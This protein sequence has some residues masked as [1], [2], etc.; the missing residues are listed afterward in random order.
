MERLSTP[1]IPTEAAAP[2]QPPPT[3]PS[4]WRSIVAST[5]EKRRQSPAK[6]RATVQRLLA[7]TEATHP[8]RLPRL[9]QSALRQR[10]AAHSEE[11]R[12]GASTPVSLR[13]VLRNDFAESK[14]QMGA[15]QLNAT[16]LF[17]GA[18]AR[19][20]RGDPGTDSEHALAVRRALRKQQRRLSPERTSEEAKEQSEFPLQAGAPAS[21][22]H[23]P[24]SSSLLLAP[25]R[26]ASPSSSSSSS[27]SSYHIAPP[28]PSELYKPVISK[29]EQLPLELFDNTEGDLTPAQWLTL[30]HSK[31]PGVG[32]PAKALFYDRGEWAW[33]PCRVTGWEEERQVWLI[34]F[35]VGDG[36]VL[37]KEVK[38]LSLLFDDEDADRFARRLDACREL[39]EECLSVRRYT[40]F[41]NA[42]S[43]ALFSPIQPATLHGI[44]GKLM[45]TSEQL[46]VRRQQT[47][48]RLLAEVKDEYN[49]AMKAAIIDY[50]RRDP[51]QEATMAALRLPPQTL[52]PPPPYLAVVPTGPH[53]LPFDALSASLATAHYTRHT[54]AGQVVLALYRAWS[55]LSGSIFF[56]L[57]FTPRDVPHAS[58]PV[59]PLTIS[60]FLIFQQQAFLSLRERCQNEWRALL[61]NLIRDNL[62]SVYKLFVNERDEYDRSELRRFL[63]VTGYMLRDQLTALVEN[64]VSQWGERMQQYQAAVEEA[65]AKEARGEDV[66]KGFLDAPT[67][68]RPPLS[69]SVAPPLF[70]FRLSFE[71]AASAIVF[72]PPLPALQSSL[73]ALLALPGKLTSL[74]HIDSD[75]V[76]L[77][78]LPDRSL[79]SDQLPSLTALIADTSALTASIITASLIQPQALAALYLPYTALLASSATLASQ[80][81]SPPHTLEETR[82]EVL[83][84]R[85][86]AQTV[87]ALSPNLVAFPLLVC[88]VVGLK[89]EL[90]GR[91]EEVVRGL[92]EGLEADVREDCASMGRSFAEMKARLEVVCTD[93]YQMSELQRFVHVCETDSVQAMGATSR[94]PRPSSR[95]CWAS[96]TPSPPRTTSACCRCRAS[97]CSWLRCSPACAPTSP[98]TA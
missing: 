60:D 14:E 95:C 26:S 2:S 36:A 91:C 50:R 28:D 96:S 48:E 77:L 39:R 76:P 44:I 80:W 13:K 74:T 15:Q 59:Y 34:R 52:P 97:L 93:V 46:V 22:Y 43:S 47:V 25:P 27:S 83:R 71:A 86:L 57:A 70:L 30:S 18:V 56:D 61:I 90:I 40:S 4:D 75:V 88:D 79:L 24:T 87:D 58:D 73:L 19:A 89:A 45:A 6:Q 10:A 16:A 17:L 51:R 5:L 21:S 62:A 81:S 92:L 53:L 78:G 29:L 33:R 32:L 42:Q 23:P 41:V 8:I 64:S 72:N 1:Q 35:E 82:A 84:Y 98:S 3:D 12:G 54:E 11:G 67:L 9:V 66:L 85:T 55:S 68:Q 20:E 94:L 65:R 31:Y 37:A 49:R 7:R 69:A 38:R 63:H